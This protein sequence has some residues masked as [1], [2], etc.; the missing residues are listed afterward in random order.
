MLTMH[1]E[2]VVDEK[3]RKKAVLVSFAEWQQLMEALEE[4]NDIR[5]YDTAK[6]EPD[7][8]APFEEAVRQIK[9][10]R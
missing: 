7:D 2:Y 1:P 8:L 5:A 4:L 3:A 6:K 10:K 9:A